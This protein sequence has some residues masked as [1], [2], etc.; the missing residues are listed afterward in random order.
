MRVSLVSLTAIALVLGLTASAWSQEGWK[1]SGAG[2][3]AKAYQRRTGYRGATDRSRARLGTFQMQRFDGIRTR[4]D[5]LDDIINSLS[6]PGSRRTENY[7]KNPIRD[8][9]EQRNLLSP[10]S[11]MASKSVSYLGRNL[12]PETSTVVPVAV[13]SGVPATTTPMPATPEMSPADK[14]IQS[15]LDDPTSQG[16]KSHFEIGVEYFRNGDYRLASSHFEVESELHYDQ[17]RPFVAGMLAAYSSE[18]FHRA[19]YRLMLAIRR[20]KT[21]DDL[22][23][24]KNAFYKTPREFDRAL[25]DVNIWAKSY[26]DTPG[27]SMMLA[28]FALFNGDRAMTLSSI[29]AAI[30]NAKTPEETAACQLFRDLL[31][32]AATTPPK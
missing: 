2:D 23:I 31:T 18:D 5:Q 32:S 30:K 7:A 6:R 14:R 17:A 22:M 28:F 3:R 26:P 20:A 13:G 1:R 21:I 16:K 24:D 25:N 27:P 10:R 29:D 19:Y 8:L 15:Y 9:L 12:I 4:S 11:P